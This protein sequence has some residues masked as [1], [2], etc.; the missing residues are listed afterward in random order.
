MNHRYHLPGQVDLPDNLSADD[1]RR[2]TAT[3]LA[4]IDR[5]IRAASTVEHRP[6]G[7]GER[8]AARERL[9]A[10]PSDGLFTLASYGGDAKA[11]LPVT[12]KVPRTGGAQLPPGTRGPTYGNLPRD[13]PGH[14]H[15]VILRQ[16][17][18]KWRE[19]LPGGKVQRAAGTYAFVIQD[20]TIYAVKRDWMTV[21]GKAA[22]HTEAAR[23]G[24]VTWAGFM[25]VA[26]R[27]GQ[28]TAWNDASGH[29]KPA[30]SLRQ[31]AIDAGLPESAWVQGEETLVRPRPT[32]V[33]PQLPVVQPDTKPRQGELRA[34][35]PPGSPRLDILEEHIRASRPTAPPA[36]SPP[37]P[38]GPPPPLSTPPAPPTETPAGHRPSIPPQG[39]KTFGRVTVAYDADAE[40]VAKRV[41]LR[42][43]DISDYPPQRM[44][45]V[46]RFLQGRELLSGLLKMAPT[47]A[48]QEATD[49][50]MTQVEN[51]FR[52]AATKAADDAREYFRP[53]GQ[54]LYEARLPDLAAA[55]DDVLEGRA[56]T[57]ARGRTLD[58]NVTDVIAYHDALVFNMAEMRRYADE[59]RPIV[60]DVEARAQVLRDVARSVEDT[61]IWV[62][63]Y[64][65]VPFAFYASL[66]LWH[67]RGTFLEFAERLNNIKVFVDA[68]VD[69]YA[70]YEK[71][72]GNELALLTEAIGDP[73]T[74]ADELLARSKGRR[75]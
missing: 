49:F 74:W 37:P 52:G 22:G 25:S 41:D 9:D 45:R 5:A 24:R 10:V 8:P 56:S 31:S 63:R 26:R 7:A 62:N 30:A 54:L 27:S 42:S 33:N 72:L 43:V 71:Q 40:N 68:R 36:T 70:Y 17:D 34:K 23:G 69:E 64:L 28:V 2:L 11:T 20:G 14:V 6:A 21:E 66:P 51:H 61:F 13:E 38:S 29:Y 65:L 18:G 16:I 67:A 48:A 53:A 4:A 60:S 35:V 46:S 44:G 73:N 75:P 32:D 15:R 12:P 19:V 3:I 47:A 57:V 58:E 55:A 1:Q 59:G 39:T 50:A